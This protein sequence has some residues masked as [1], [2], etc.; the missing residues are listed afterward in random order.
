MLHP[1]C[2]SVAP[3]EQYPSLGFFAIYGFQDATSLLYKTVHPSVHSS[4]APLTFFVNQ[5]ISNP[6]RR[7]AQPI[8][9]IY[10]HPSLKEDLFVHPS[11]HGSTSYGLSLRNPVSKTNI[12]FTNKGGSRRLERSRKWESFF[13]LHLLL[14]ASHDVWLTACL[15]LS[16]NL[17]LCV[18]FLV[19]LCLL[20]CACV[21]ACV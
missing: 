5:S 11:V 4:F 9:F 2:Q 15:F 17:S 16:F 20:V 12:K 21:L 14:C 1:V 8:M 7:K 18:S 13:S 6:M 3:E 19:F 10:V